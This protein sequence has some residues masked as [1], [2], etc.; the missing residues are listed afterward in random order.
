MSVSFDPDSRHV[1]DAKRSRYDQAAF[2]FTRPASIITDTD[3]VLPTLYTAST[4]L[5]NERISDGLRA[6]K[7]RS[8]WAAPSSQDNRYETEI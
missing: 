2:Y 4:F 1:R 5:G 3:E 6:L 7:L 8:A